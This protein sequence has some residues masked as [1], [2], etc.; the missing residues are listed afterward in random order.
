M[1]VITVNQSDWG[2]IKVTGPDRIRFLNGMVTSNIKTLEEGGWL[3]TILL[4]HKARVLSIFDVNAHGD[5]RSAH[6]DV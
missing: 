2:H 3:R 1:T 6:R 4:N 5:F